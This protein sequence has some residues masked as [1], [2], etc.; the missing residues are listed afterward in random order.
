MDLSSEKLSLTTEIVVPFHDLDPL[1]IVWHGHYVKYAEIARNR[2][3][4]EI[5]YDYPDMKASGYAWPIIEFKM[6]YIKPATYGMKLLVQACI[7]EIQNRLYVEYLITDTNK[8]RI[9]KGYSIQVAVD[10]KTG[11]M[12]LASPQ[13]L[14]D[15][16]SKRLSES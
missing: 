13:I 5:H 6:R 2:L 14:Q 4:Q 8:K 16:I 1:E 7:T 9:S 12:C 3:L 11:E 15:L 10:I